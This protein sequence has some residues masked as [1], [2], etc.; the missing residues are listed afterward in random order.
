M[1]AARKGFDSIVA[2]RTG[3][4]LQ[5]SNT[6]DLLAGWVGLGGLAV[7]LEA[8]AAAGRDAEAFNHAQGS[9]RTDGKAATAEVIRT[10]NSLQKEYSLAMAVV[11]A[12]RGDFARANADDALLTRLDD[13]IANTASVTVDIHEQP[14]G[15]KSRTT[16]KALSQEAIRAEIQRDAEALLG[17]A[18]VQQALAA[19][20]L[21]AT[22][23]QALRD[24]A[25]ALSGKLGDRSAKKGAAK[26][27][28]EREREAA[29]TQRDLWGGVYGI[30]SAL[31]RKDARV[32]VLLKEARG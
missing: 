7:D 6:P 22:R 14:D 13:I 30:L 3:A 15:K 10:F 4:A 26:D 16:S 24:D 11:R 20:K 18:G 31:G 28:T 12:V 19:R 2:A 32:A 5:I 9:A 27:A 1:A 25:K 21:D 29:A 8:I 23:L 17:F